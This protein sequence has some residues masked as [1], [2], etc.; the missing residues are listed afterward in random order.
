MTSPQGIIMLM[1]CILIKRIF[2]S[3]R[4]NL[5]QTGNKIQQLLNS[6]NKKIRYYRKVKCFWI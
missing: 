5:L 6:V 2:V 1:I 4:K 3:L